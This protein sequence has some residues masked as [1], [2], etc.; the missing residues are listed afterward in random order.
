MQ[1]EH[2]LNI[3]KANQEQLSKSEK[4]AKLKDGIVLAGSGDHRH[5]LTISYSS[6]FHHLVHVKC[7]PCFNVQTDNTQRAH[8][9]GITATIYTFFCASGTK[10]CVIS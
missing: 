7:F 1:K 9:R 10:G 5:L 3:A 4:D 6:H 8:T 2:L